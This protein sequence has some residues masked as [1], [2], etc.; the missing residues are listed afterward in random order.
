MN[1]RLSCPFAG[2]LTMSVFFSTEPPPADPRLAELWALLE[3]EAFSDAAALAEDASLDPRAPVEWFCGLSLA[4]GELGDY[5]GAETVARTALSF[6]ERPW[7]VRHALAVALMHQGRVLGALDAL[8]YHRAPP[9][10][11]VVRAQ[12]ELMGGYTEGLAVTLE[13]ARDLNVPPAIALI[14]AFLAAALA[15]ATGDRAGWQDA[16]AR[17]RQHGDAIRVWERDAGRHRATPY[18]ELLA[19]Q[20]STLHGWLAPER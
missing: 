8:G 6:R 10:I 12:V 14:L 5:A 17:A 20:I 13:G 16:V 1:V 15:E 11:L 9:E 18:G 7:R 2:N 4:Y 19:A 3:A